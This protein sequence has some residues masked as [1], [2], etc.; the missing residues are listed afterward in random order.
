MYVELG[1]DFERA[2]LWRMS[3]DQVKYLEGKE[4]AGR[5]LH[6]STFRKEAERLA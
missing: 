3:V 2:S 5:A 1:D 4:S 6:V